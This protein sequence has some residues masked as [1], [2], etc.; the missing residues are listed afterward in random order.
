MHTLGTKCTLKKLSASSHSL[1]LADQLLGG[2]L[3]WG[4]WGSLEGRVEGMS[5]AGQIASSSVGCAWI[6]MLVAEMVEA[7]GWFCRNTVPKVCDQTIKTFSTLWAGCSLLLRFPLLDGLLRQQVVIL[8]ALTLWAMF[9]VVSQPHKVSFT[10]RVL[11]R[12]GWLLH[13]E[14]TTNK[15]S[16]NWPSGKGTSCWL[17]ANVTMGIHHRC[18]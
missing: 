8:S 4:N 11:F 1:C 6:E 12:G 3:Q 16:S 17:C 14:M 13:D 10:E 9:E 18:S 15:K 2:P 7:V 5:E